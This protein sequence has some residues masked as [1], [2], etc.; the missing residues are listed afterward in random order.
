M[1]Q[2]GFTHHEGFSWESSMDPSWISQWID[3]CEFS[4]RL[5]VG[6]LTSL[7]C[8]SDH[9]KNTCFIWRKPKKRFLEQRSKLVK[10]EILLLEGLVLVGQVFFD[11]FVLIIKVENFPKWKEINIWDTSIFHWTTIMGGRADF[12]MLFLIFFELFLEGWLTLFK[13]FKRRKLGW[14]VSGTD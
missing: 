1:Q 2:P 8:L 9:K 5:D 7:Q 13:R 10:V 6:T 12:W 4:S 3:H 14:H 11:G